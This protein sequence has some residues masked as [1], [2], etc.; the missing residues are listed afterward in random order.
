VTVAGG[1]GREDSSGVLHDCMMVGKA[2]LQRKGGRVN[3]G[4]LA[5][6]RGKNNGD[7]ARLQRCSSEGTTTAL[8]P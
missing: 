7:A 8:A 2:L 3:A 5:H 6:Q 4:V 1:E